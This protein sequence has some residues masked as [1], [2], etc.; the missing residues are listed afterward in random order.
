MDN[1]KLIEILRQ[2]PAVRPLRVY[3]L[4]WQFVN[5]DG[6]LDLQKVIAGVPDLE[7]AT[8]EAKRYMDG[9]ADLR[10]LLGSLVK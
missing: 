3:R 8:M 6:T 7:E 9:V 2:V 4:A 1:Q 5:E 10:R